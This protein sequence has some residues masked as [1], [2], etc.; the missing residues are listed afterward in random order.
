MTPTWTIRDAVAA[1]ADTIVAFNQALARES[2]G[3]EIDGP[4]LTRGVARA[5]ADP[6]CGRYFMADEAGRPI[7]QTL[8]THEWSDWRC[9]WF[10]WIQS[11]YVIPERRRQGVFRG[12]YE[13]IAAAARRQGD[14][15]GLRLY[16]EDHNTA[17]QATYAALGM[18]RTGYHVLEHDWSSA[19]RPA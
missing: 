16:V 10:W 6:T 3:R 12:L 5:L 11:V 17:G 1:D 2:E 18:V 4:T 14:V 19:V 15:C 7:G 8:I 9:G 13:H